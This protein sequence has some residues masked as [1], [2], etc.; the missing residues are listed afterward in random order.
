MI[1]QFNQTILT[2]LKSIDLMNQISEREAL[3]TNYKSEIKS[4][5]ATINNYKEKITQFQIEQGKKETISNELKNENININS[6]NTISSILI[7]LV[8]LIV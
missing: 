8:V 5:K 2:I 3:I 4:L 7:Q 1:D 6:I